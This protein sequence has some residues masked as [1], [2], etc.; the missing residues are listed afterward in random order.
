M[1]LVFQGGGEESTI[2]GVVVDHQ[3]VA[4]ATSG[5]LSSRESL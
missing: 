2:Q 5:L 4:H 3:D 1:P